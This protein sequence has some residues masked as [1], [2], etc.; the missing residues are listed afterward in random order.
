[1]KQQ[2]KTLLAGGLLALALFGTAMAGSTDAGWAAYDKDDYAT[3]LRI[4]HQ[5]DEQ[6]DRYA[7]DPIALMY[8]QGRGVP[9]DYEQAFAWHLKS[10]ERENAQAQVSV[11]S[12]Y[13]YGKG[14][15]KD[16]VRAHMW[17]NLASADQWAMPEDATDANRRTGEKLRDKVAAQMT[18]DQIA[19]AQRM[20]RKWKPKGA[21]AQSPD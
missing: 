8:E 1:M 10:A 4:F 6:G 20:A 9:Q 7:P 17:Y 21:Q 14:V 15:P 2:I 18:P 12:M 11:G 16:Y 3:A 5:L 19:E 13:E